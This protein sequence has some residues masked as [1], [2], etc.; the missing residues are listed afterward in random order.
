MSG[1]LSKTTNVFKA[2]V[3]DSPQ[4]YQLTC[5][6]GETLRGLRGEHSQQVRCKGCGT[7]LFVLPKDVYPLARRAGGKAELNST[8]AP[9][10]VLGEETI[11]ILDAVDED[12]AELSSSPSTK[13]KIRRGADS[14]AEENALPT[15]EQLRQRIREAEKPKAPRKVA[16][17]VPEKVSPVE[18]A[19]AAVGEYVSDIRVGLA[20][21]WTPFRML[22]V[23]VGVIILFTAAWTIRQSIQARAVRIA[24][25]E[26]EAGLAAIQKQDWIGAR[27][28]LQLAAG[29]L[30]RLGRVD[31]DAQTIRQYARETQALFRMSDLN[32]EDLLT[33]AQKELN[34]RDPKKQSRNNL[35]VAHRGDWILIEGVV[36]DVT[37]TP[38]KIRQFEMKLPFGPNGSDGETRV[39]MN[40]PVFHSLIPTGGEKEVIAAGALQDCEQN[41]DGEWIVTLNP[42]SGFLW[43]HQNTYD[44]TGLSSNALRSEKDLESKLGTQAEAMGVPE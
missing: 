39:K 26:G 35:A 15:L 7:S 33:E 12:S 40:F 44:A 28:H 43:T 1:W 19:G 42:Q 14:P 2:E 8:W 5:S 38:S 25:Q 11:P 21:F 36:H 17:A 6:C 27:E 4:P 23:V 24:Q 22:A 13:K 34:A 18:K 29:A 9:V 20:R 10:T 16:D 37:Q 3:S 30:D 32:L 41:A 31:P